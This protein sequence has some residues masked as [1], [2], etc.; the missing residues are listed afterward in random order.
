[1]L[2]GSR[3]RIWNLKNQKKKQNENHQNAR[4]ID[5]KLETKVWYSLLQFS[6]VICKISNSNM[7]TTKH[8]AQASWT[9][10]TLRLGF[11]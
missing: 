2:S 11:N 7:W 4:F 1:M 6:N 9:E 8:L 5:E 10:L 3:I